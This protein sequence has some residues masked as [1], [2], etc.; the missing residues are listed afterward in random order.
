[1]AIAKTIEGLAAMKAEILQKS[2]D[3]VVV[4]TDGW[5]DRRNCSK[6]QNALSQR[7]K[8]R[9]YSRQCKLKMNL[10]LLLLYLD[11]SPV[12]IVEPS[13]SLNQRSAEKRKSLREMTYARYLK[14]A[15]L[16]NYPIS[17]VT[18]EPTKCSSQDIKSQRKDCLSD[19]TVQEANS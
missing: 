18:I 9:R 8:T 7:T 1:M 6:L 4:N 19:Y 13:S 15:K 5:V 11:D 17:Q 10:D 14:N 3:F 2:V 16:Q 12:I